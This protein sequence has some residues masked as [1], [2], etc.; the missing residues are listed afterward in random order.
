MK[1]LLADDDIKIHT[2]VRLWLGNH[3]HEVHSAY[4]GAQALQMISQEHFDGLISDVNMPIMRGNDLVGKVLEL[5]DAPELIVVLT[6][7]CD[8]D[9]LAEQFGSGKVHLFNKPFSPSALVKLINQ[10]GSSK[11]LK[12]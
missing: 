11:A 9:Q 12:T 2:V 7:R 5:P 1:I 8:M 10:L 4:N 6:S 3:G